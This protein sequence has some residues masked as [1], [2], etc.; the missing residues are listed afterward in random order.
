MTRSKALTAS[1]G[2]LKLKTTVEPDM[3]GI[4]I[5]AMHVAKFGVGLVNIYIM[6]SISCFFYINLITSNFRLYMVRLKQR[7]RVPDLKY[8]MF[9]VWNPSP[10]A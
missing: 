6:L 7:G 8:N 2:W 9:Q 10:Y 5:R 1:H 4:L 3:S